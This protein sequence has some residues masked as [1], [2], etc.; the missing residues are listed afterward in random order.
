MAQALNRWLPIDD[1]PVCDT[2]ARR[3]DKMAFKHG[4]ASRDRDEGVEFSKKEE[5]LHHVENMKDSGG[6]SM[7]SMHGK[8]MRNAAHHT[9][10]PVS[11]HKEPH[12]G[13]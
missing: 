12:E 3:G 8:E 2:I 10:R 13:M 11:E 4:S 9:G 6:M 1:L 5:D 7:K